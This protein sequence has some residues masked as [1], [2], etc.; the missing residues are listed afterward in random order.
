MSCVATVVAGFQPATG[1][2]IN[3]SMPKAEHFTRGLRIG[4]EDK[5]TPR[6]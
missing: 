2:V 5:E 3:G 6:N 4:K 1:I